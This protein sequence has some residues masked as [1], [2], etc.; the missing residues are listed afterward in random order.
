MRVPEDVRVKS[1]QVDQVTLSTSE[2]SVSSAR[3]FIPSRVVQTVVYEHGEMTGVE[4]YHITCGCKGVENDGR[5]VVVF[6]LC[7]VAYRAMKHRHAV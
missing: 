3:V 4:V 6:G 7:E 1:D 2:Y 5:H